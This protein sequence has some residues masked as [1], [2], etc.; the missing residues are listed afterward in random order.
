MEGKTLTKLHDNLRVLRN[1]YK[2]SQGE[3]ARKLCVPR[4]R[5]ERWESGI[6]PPL[7]MVLNMANFYNITVEQLLTEL[8]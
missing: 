8:P 5:Y 2:Y 7:L 4:T 3:V 6:E 1:R